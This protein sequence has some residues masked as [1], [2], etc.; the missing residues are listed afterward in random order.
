MLGAS[1]LPLILGII[2]IK[3]YKNHYLIFDNHGVEVQSFRGVIIYASWH[4]ITSGKFNAF[5]G[6]I[7]FRLL[8]RNEKIKINRHLVGMSSFFDALEANTRIN[9]SEIKMHLN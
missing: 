6:D 2:C 5:S 3:Y 7:V 4:E 1:L 9:S 8:N